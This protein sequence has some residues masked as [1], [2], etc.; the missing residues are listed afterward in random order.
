M[1]DQLILPSLEIQG[2]RAF[3]KLEIERLGRVNLIV[4]KNNV[5]KSSILEALRLYANPSPRTLLDLISTR[6]EFDQPRSQRPNGRRSSLVPIGALFHGRVAIPDRTPPISIGPIG[7]AHR[8]VQFGLAIRRHQGI[9]PGEPSRTE[10]I[11][12]DLSEVIPLLSRQIGTRARRYLSIDDLP[13]LAQYEHI[14]TPETEDLD[15]ITVPRPYISSNGPD[16]RS[17]V[18]YWHRINLTEYQKTITDSL[19]LSNR[20]LHKYPRTLIQ[21]TN[22]C[23]SSVS[24]VRPSLSLF[25]AW[26]RE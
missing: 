3:R 10:D 23:R 26:A 20:G 5:G 13:R 17:T 11:D 12:G 22:W 16:P 8:T 9:R 18:E 14:M 4:G 21:P 24:R 15:A 7:D 1:S 25:G 6:D 2:F 19:R